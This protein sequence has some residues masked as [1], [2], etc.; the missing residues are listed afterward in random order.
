MFKSAYHFYKESNY[1][2]QTNRASLISNKS[3]NILP[4]NKRS[5]I[6]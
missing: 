5:L 6:E 3:Q 2:L 4:N 1:D